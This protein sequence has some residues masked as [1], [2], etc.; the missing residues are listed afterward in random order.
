MKFKRQ[1]ILNLILFLS[2]SLISITYA[3]YV[4][5]KT[6]ELTIDSPASMEAGAIDITLANEQNL[7]TVHSQTGTIEIKTNIELANDDNITYQSYYAWTETNSEPNESDYQE[8]I[9]TENAYTATKQA[10]LGTHYLWVKIKYTTELGEAKQVIKTSRLI[11]VVYGDIEIELEDEESEYLTGDVKVNISYKG[12][13]TQNT[14]AGYGK[15]LEEAIQNATIEQS[16][17]ITILEEK[18]DTTY[19]I[20]AYAEDENGNNISTTREITNIDNISPE[21]E[22]TANY[23][24]IKLKLS[25]N[26]SGVKYYTVTL[27]NTKPTQYTYSFTTPETEIE[28]YIENLEQNTTYYIWVKDSVGNITSQE[29][30]TKT[31]TYTITPKLTTWTK[32]VTK[33]EFDNIENCTLTYNFGGTATYTY[34]NEK[35]IEV[36][37][38]HNNKLY[39]TRWK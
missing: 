22:A 30:K 10:G 39:I 25:D 17:E 15:T 21:I 13:Y 29:I 32:D 19:Y 8:F 2:L 4:I 11:N 24:R 9:F 34:N 14:K 12:L 23:A 26:K 3:R 6:V 7:Y 37:R 5:S 18:E 1:I 28:T 31:L 27:T 38:K 36:S 33:V 20:Y 16:N 35:G